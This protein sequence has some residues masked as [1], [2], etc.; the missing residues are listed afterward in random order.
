MGIQLFRCERMSAMI[1]REQCDRNRYGVRGATNRGTIP[2]RWACEG[3][4]GLELDAIAIDTEVSMAGTKCKEPGCEK[5]VTRD[6]YCWGHCKMH[7]I[8][9]KTGK[10]LA[11]VSP[12]PVVDRTVPID[13]A[14]GSTDPR[15]TFE[16]PHC[17]CALSS[18][19]VDL[20]SCPM[21]GGQLHTHVDQAGEVFTPAAETADDFC[22]ACGT[23]PCSCAELGGMGAST[24]DVAPPV[25]P[26]PQLL[27]RVTNIDGDQVGFGVDAVVLAAIDEALADLRTSMLTDLSGLAPGRMICET[28]RKLERIQTLRG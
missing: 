27:D 4:P 20:P 16:C 3:C 26:T 23:Y 14:V 10:P 8:D 1:S 9:S 25:P 15:E 17:G 28:Y 21:C 2:P 11:G 13:A 7:G 24:T 18:N 5:F 22:T 19:E 6:G 12:A